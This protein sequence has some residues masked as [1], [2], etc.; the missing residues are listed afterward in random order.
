MTS[1]TETRGMSLDRPGWS[2]RR[3]RVRSRSWS[4]RS[5]CC[6]QHRGLRGARSTAPSARPTRSPRPDENLFTRAF[7]ANVHSTFGVPNPCRIRGQKESFRGYS[8]PPC[9]QLETGSKNAQRLR[10]SAEEKGFEPLVPLRARRFSKPV[11]STARPLLPVFSGF[12]RC[13]PSGPVGS[14]R[15]RLPS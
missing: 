10:K 7:T 14:R 15:P 3:A 13:R 1:Y 5:V 8:G 2:P 11:P 9:E 12:T 6:I 4:M